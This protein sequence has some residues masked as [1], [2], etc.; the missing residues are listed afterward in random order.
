VIVTV[1]VAVFVIPP[2]LVA[3]LGNGN[4]TMAVTDAV[5]DS[6]SA[7]RR[8]RARPQRG[9]DRCIVMKLDLRRARNR[10]WI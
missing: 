10:G 4:D 5:N 6:P 9:D 3:A 8:L 7:G 1:T 2:V